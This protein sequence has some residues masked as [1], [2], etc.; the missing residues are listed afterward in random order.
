MKIDYEFHDAVAVASKNPLFPIVLRSIADVL[1]HVR[2]LGVRLPDYQ[3][4]S[5]HH[6]RNIYQALRVAAPGKARKAMESHLREAEKT[7]RRALSEQVGRS[8][9]G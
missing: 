1:M 4:K 2:L 8:G 9:P 3:A 6:H 5:L 7:M